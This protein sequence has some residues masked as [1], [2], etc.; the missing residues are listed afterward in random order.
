SPM[1]GT[2]TARDTFHVARTPT[3][4]IAEPL[5]PPLPNPSTG[6]RV[7]RSTTKPGMVF[8]TVMPS[9]PQ[10][11]EI[12]A[13]PA[14]SLSVGD[15]FTNTVR[16]VIARVEETTTLSDAGSAPNSRPPWRVFGQLT[17]IS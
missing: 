15:S 3:G 16:Q 13:A 2:F 7:S 4:R 9:A 1:T 11:T 5:T 14:I 8:T 12:F 6:F 17:L 10:S